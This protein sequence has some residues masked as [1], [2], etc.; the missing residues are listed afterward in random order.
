MNE[1]LRTSVWESGQTRTSAFYLDESEIIEAILI[2]LISTSNNMFNYALSITLSHGLFRCLLRPH[3]VCSGSR[4]EM[5][6]E[7]NFIICCTSRRGR[8]EIKRDETDWSEIAHYM[9]ET[10]CVKRD[11]IVNL[12]AERYSICECEEREILSFAWQ[13]FLRSVLVDFLI[14]V[15]FSYIALLSSR[16]GPMSFSRA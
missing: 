7:N 6:I 8:Y 15:T 16:I 12:S 14:I 10:W 3:V 4:F 13:T 1:L 2:M 9:S 5:K 11:K